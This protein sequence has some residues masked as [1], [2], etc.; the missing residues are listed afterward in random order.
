MPSGWW[1]LV[2]NL[3]PSIALTQNFVPKAHLHK[4]I[5][6]LRD[7]K[8]GISGFRNDV[9]DPYELFIKRLQEQYPKDFEEAI[10]RLQNK[11]RKWEDLVNG[12]NEESEKGG[13][14]SFGFGGEDELG[15]ESDEEAP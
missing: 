4:V 12:N 3:E 7:Q 8:N 5:A 6:F 15:E 13:G 9:E 10:D 11:K 1:H 14:F 2:V